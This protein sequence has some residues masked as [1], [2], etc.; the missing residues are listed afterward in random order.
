MISII[1]LGLGNIG[2]VENILKH[3]G[4]KVSLV[5]T[6]NEIIKSSKLI[7]PGVGSFD[8]GVSMIEN[9]NLRESLE[10]AVYEKKIP[11]LGI[12]LGMQLLSQSSSEG[13]LEGLG[14]IKGRCVKFGEEEKC[15]NRVPFMGWGEVNLQKD[16]KLFNKLKQNHFYFTHSY[17][18]KLENENNCLGKTDYGVIYTSAISDDH[19]YGVQFHPEKS[20]KFGM[21]LFRNFIE[22]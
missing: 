17:Y 21:Q 14:F 10:A 18:L 9:L 12:C 16:S 2:S 20:H 5:K 11:I 7:L 4:S 19:I 3:I 15:N 6:P 8:A 22:L 13:S 1:D